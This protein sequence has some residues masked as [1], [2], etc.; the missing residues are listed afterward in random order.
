M[1]EATLPAG[2]RLVSPEVAYAEPGVVTAGPETIEALKAIAR[3]SP[4]RRA[5]LCAHPDSD[6]P[7]QEMLIVMHRSSYVRPH[8]HWRKSET[9]IVLEGEAD[10]L[11]FDEDG[12]VARTLPMGPYGSGRLFFYR[13]PEGVFHGLI[14]RTEWMVFL[15]TTAGPFDPTRS[16]GAPWAP[17]ESDQAAGHAWL[18]SVEAAQA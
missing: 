5:R 11:L 17:D 15:E 13:M 18:A 9:F 14:F 8:R 7:Q 2:V 1:S 3:T 16:E 12:G 4:R 6:A 10:A